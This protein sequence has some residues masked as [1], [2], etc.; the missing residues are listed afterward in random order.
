M[1]AHESSWVRDRGS[2]VGWLKRLR[3]ARRNLSCKEAPLQEPA[4]SGF[5]LEC[6]VFNNDVSAR[7]SDFRHT[8]ASA[9]FISAVVHS[10]VVRGGAD[11]QF[12][13][14]IEDHDV[15]VGTNGDRALLRE[16]T[17]DFRSC[18]RCEFNE[19]IEAD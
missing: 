6:P 19:P 5:A 18:R 9:P 7:Q 15:G 3:K 14:W 4:L 11:D 12:T 10:H 16:Q 2:R 17:K 13:F 1:S 8:A